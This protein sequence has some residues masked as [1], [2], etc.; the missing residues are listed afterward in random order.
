M[1]EFMDAGQPTPPE[2]YISELELEEHWGIPRE[3]LHY[4]STGEDPPIPVTPDDRR[5]R[6]HVVL[7]CIAMHLGVPK[8]VRV[9][10]TDEPLI[11]EQFADWL[12]ERMETDKEED[13]QQNPLDAALC[14]TLLDLWFADDSD[15]LPKDESWWPTI[16]VRDYEQRPLVTTLDVADEWDRWFERCETENT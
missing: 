8:I 5:V 4:W 12:R 14:Q 10:K 3:V 2:G 7:N 6:R 13:F 15:D 1:I 9:D 16:L 11:A